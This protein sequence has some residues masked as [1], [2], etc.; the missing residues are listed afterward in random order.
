MDDKG[1]HIE[2]FWEGDK[3]KSCTVL[4]EILYY[5]TAARYELAIWSSEITSVICQITFVCCQSVTGSSGALMGAT[6]REDF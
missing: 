6:V 2:V 3:T 4:R 1:T 5:S